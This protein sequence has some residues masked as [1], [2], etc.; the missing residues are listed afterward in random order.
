MPSVDG[1]LADARHELEYGRGFLL[2][3]GLPIEFPL[4]EG[5]RQWIAKTEQPSWRQLFLPDL[6]RSTV[7]ATFES[8]SLQRRVYREP[9]FRGASVRAPNGG[10]RNSSSFTRQFIM[11]RRK[12]RIFRERILLSGYQPVKKSKL[13]IGKTGPGSFVSA[14]QHFLQ[15]ASP[16]GLRTR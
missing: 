15:A 4:D 10:L 11:I 7:M 6:R 3:R 9:D 2:L 16:S 8:S 1:L 5:D 13:R 14:G 12:S